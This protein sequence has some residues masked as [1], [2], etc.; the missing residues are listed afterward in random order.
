MRKILESVGLAAL[1]LLA[2]I[3]LRALRGPAR[4]PARIP[5]HFDLAGHPDAWGSP[6]MLLLL[7]A[8]AAAVYLLISVVARLPGAFNYP[9]RVTAQNRPRLEAL[10]LAMI[11]WLKAEL[12]C[13]FAAIQWFSIQAARDPRRGLP[14]NIMPAILVVVF[15]TI[16]WYTCAMFR[17]GRNPARS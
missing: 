14:A 16:A 3:T 7:P 11:T 5:T 10:A 8:V 15:A 13:L 4:L 2:W 1:A 6:A 9:V 17:V 12:A